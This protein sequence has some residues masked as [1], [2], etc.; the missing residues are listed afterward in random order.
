MV[1]LLNCFHFFNIHWNFWLTFLKCNWWFFVFITVAFWECGSWFAVYWGR[2]WSWL[3]LVY[4]GWSWSVYGCW[5]VVYWNDK[6]RINWKSCY[7]FSWVLNNFPSKNKILFIGY[8]LHI[9]KH[10]P[11]AG[12]GAGAWYTGAGAW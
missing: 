1:V 8:E 10:L 12:A 2:L 4:W 5:C 11:G 7:Y 3:R 6:L 9:M